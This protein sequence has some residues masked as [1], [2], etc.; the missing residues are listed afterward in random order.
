MRK[1]ALAV[2]TFVALILLPRVVPAL[3]DY[4]SLDPRDIPLVWDLP[5]PKP[6]ELET[7]EVRARRLQ[8]QAPQNLIDPQKSWIISMG[9]CSEAG[10][11]GYCTTAIRPPPAI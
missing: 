11:C 8:A 10:R 5:V 9:R 6:K 1:T 3:K 4:A 2:A 7:D